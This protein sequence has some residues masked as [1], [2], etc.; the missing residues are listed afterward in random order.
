MK[1]YGFNFK[2]GLSLKQ[3]KIKSYQ[4]QILCKFKISNKKTQNLDKISIYKYNSM[5]ISYFKTI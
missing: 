2:N 4:F 3:I 1:I 5:I